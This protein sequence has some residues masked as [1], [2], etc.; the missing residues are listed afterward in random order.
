MTGMTT[1]MNTETKQSAAEILRAAAAV[2]E[3]RGKV[4]DNAQGERSMARCV[5]AFNAL[6]GRELTEIEGWLFMSVLKMARATAGE[7]HLDDWIDL[8]GYAA[9]GAECLSRGNA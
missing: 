3:E 5:T 8:S 2:I 6:T 7:P 1:D 9:L 4:R